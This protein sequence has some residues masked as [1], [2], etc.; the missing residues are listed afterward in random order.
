MGWLDPR[1]KA[2]RDEL[3]RGGRPAQAYMDQGFGRSPR[4]DED[5]EQSYE[6]YRQQAALM[7]AIL[8][9]YEDRLHAIEGW[10]DGMEGDARRA[11]LLAEHE[12]DGHD[13]WVQGCPTC[14][15]NE[16]VALRA[17]GA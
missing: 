3:R 1:I 16:R 14:E 5:P 13:G 9:N 15:K 7:T 4:G 2:V 10:I 12:R 6:E 17:M 11:N 8:I